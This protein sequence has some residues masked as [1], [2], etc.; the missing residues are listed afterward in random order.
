MGGCN[1]DAWVNVWFIA[2]KYRAKI[3]SQIKGTVVEVNPLCGQR[4]SLL[5]QI[6]SSNNCIMLRCKFLIAIDQIA[7]KAYHN[8]NAVVRRE[9]RAHVSLL[10]Q[11]TILSLVA[12]KH[13]HIQETWRTHKHKT[14]YMQLCI[15]H[16]RHNSWS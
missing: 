3:S 13:L 10:W 1:N 8:S 4:R 14:Q 15:S 6:G 12:I 7:K 5:A 2:S 16:R 9:D 11:I